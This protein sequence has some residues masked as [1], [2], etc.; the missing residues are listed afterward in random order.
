MKNRL[1]LFIGGIMI[2]IGTL[3]AGDTNV[4]IDALVNIDIPK[5]SET[6]QSKFSNIKDIVKEQ[7]DKINLCIFNKIFADIIKNYSI[8]QQQLNDIYVAAAKDFFGG[9]LKNK[10]DGL[11]NLLVDA[12]NEVTG[13]EVHQLSQNEKSELQNRF[14][15]IAWLLNN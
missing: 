7:E 8:D 6:M 3:S 1:L 13:E 10:Y 5:P 4:G 14:Y 2:I 9:S 12:I 15:A 11:D